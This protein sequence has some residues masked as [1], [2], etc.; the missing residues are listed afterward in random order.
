MSRGPIRWFPPFQRLESGPRCYT[1]VLH[2]CC[3]VNGEDYDYGRAYEDKPT[4]EQT[5][6]FKQEAEWAFAKVE[7]AQSKGP[8]Q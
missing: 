6:S 7:A 4:A 5:E 2:A 3:V 8:G 1:W